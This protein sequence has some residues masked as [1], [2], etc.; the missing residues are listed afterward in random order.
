MIA[1]LRKGKLLRLRPTMIIFHRWAGLVLA[2]FLILSGLTGSILAW[3]AELEALLSP[4]LFLAEAPSQHAPMLDPL[5][6][7]EQMLQQYPAADIP[8]VPLFTETGHATVFFLAPKSTGTDPELEND[9]VFVHPYTG[10]ILGERKFGLIAQGK[11]NLMPFIYRLHRS[12]ALGKVGTYVFGLVALLWTLDCFFGAYLSLPPPAR[13]THAKS[14]LRRWY[15]SW[16]LRRNAGHYKL[17]FDLH[18]A[19]G[20]WLWAMLFILAWSGVAFNLQQVYTPVMQTMFRHQPGDNIIPA[21]SKAQHAPGISWV[22]ARDTGRQLMRQQAIINGFDIRREDSL[23][24]DAGKAVFRYDVLSSADI[25]THSGGT[26]LW[27]DANTG[28]F[29]AL[30]L[31]TGGATGDTLST[32]ITSLHMAAL[33]GLPFKLFICMMGMAVTGLSAT[34]IVIWAKKRRARLSSLQQRATMP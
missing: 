12:L 19:G 24:Y 10:R 17:H 31:P 2:G 32:W 30:S 9:Q 4:E 16:K 5:S 3:N 22:Q 18:R 25:R 21:L 33:W 7:R 1:I 11:K 28:A 23:Y 27:F 6:L 13:Q 15:P 34:G 8:Y 26:S 29:L 20:L 14:W